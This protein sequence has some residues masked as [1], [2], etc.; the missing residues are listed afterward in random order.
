MGRLIGFALTQRLLMVLFTVLLAGG[1]YLAFK[2][3]PIDAFPDV[4][5]TQVKI[6]IKAPGMTPEEVEARITAPVEV[7]LLGI[8]KQVMLRS[9]AKYA[10]SDIT[11]DFEEGTD[12]YWARQQVAERLNGVWEK[13]PQ[14]ITGGIA[15]MTTPLGEMFMF[16]VESDRLSLM[17]R[18]N[19][20]DWTIRPALRTVPGVADVNALGGFVRAFE[21]VPDNARLSARGLTVADL[22]GALAANNRNDGAGRMNEGEEALMV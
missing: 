12:I 9:V 15:P 21:V 22:R 5:P 16:T 4:S 18:R 6:I 14:G 1:G 7:E 11:L 20:L 2:G 3:L 8:P 13:L 17:E 10:L 19:L